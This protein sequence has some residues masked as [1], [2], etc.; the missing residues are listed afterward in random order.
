MAPSQVALSLNGQEVLFQV[1][2]STGF[3]E[4]SV[5]DN[6]F[7]ANPDCTGQAFIDGSISPATNEQ[8]FT[9]AFQVF[10]GVAYYPTEPIM[11]GTAQSQ[12]AQADETTCAHNGGRFISPDLCCYPASASG[13]QALDTF[14][15][16]TLALTPPFHVEGP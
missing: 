1:K 14:D 7:F 4:D 11:F 15:L 2:K 12:L 8:L 5:Y 6:F 9:E 13:I 10:R 3:V 16:G